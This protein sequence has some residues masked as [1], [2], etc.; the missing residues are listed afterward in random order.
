MMGRTI[1]N[2][3]SLSDDI[4]RASVVTAST[5][6]LPIRPAFLILSLHS[7]SRNSELRAKTDGVRDLRF[8]FRD[9]AQ[10]WATDEAQQTPAVAQASSHPPD[11][12]RPDLLLFP[13]TCG[14][15]LLTVLHVD[16]YANYRFIDLRRAGFYF[17]QGG[18][19]KP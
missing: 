6:V 7:T 14:A 15:G 17:G 12:A 18:G 8:C 10:R 9:G 2:R 19:P 5:K 13:A 16:L 11:T 4:G 1:T 3:F